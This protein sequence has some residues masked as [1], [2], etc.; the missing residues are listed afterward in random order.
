MRVRRLAQDPTRSFSQVVPDSQ[1]SVLGVALL[2]ET[3]RIHAIIDPINDLL[4]ISE[5]VGEGQGAL[6]A[7]RIPSSGLKELEE[8]GHSVQ[9][10]A[11][12]SQLS[13]SAAQGASFV[14]D[15]PLSQSTDRTVTRG[16]ATAEHKR[17][18]KPKSIEELFRAVE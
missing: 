4:K 11:S 13:Q 1:F 15:A 3:A 10:P 6:G 5:A 18:R 2:A 12:S 17:R 14:P 8:V 16:Q 7:S 9:R